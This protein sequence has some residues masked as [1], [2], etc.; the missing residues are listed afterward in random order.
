[1]E[2]TLSTL[3]KLR[4][5][6]ISRLGDVKANLN[7]ALSFGDYIV[8]RWEKAEALGFGEGTSVYDST[9]ILGNVSVGENTWIGPFV[10]LDGSGKLRIGAN[11]SISAGVQV[12]SHDSVQWAVSGGREPY[13]Y[14]ETEIGDNCYLGPNSIVA[15][16]V[17]IGSGSVIG[18]NSLVLKSIP[19]GSK[20]YGSPCRVV[21][22]VQSASQGSEC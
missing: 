21:G 10:V 5:V 1:M 15:K 22:M 9:I 11:C 8:D 14:A 6:W 13:E 17:K 18:A 19:A 3:A 2:D 16:G 20:A 12:Y 4:A 7:R